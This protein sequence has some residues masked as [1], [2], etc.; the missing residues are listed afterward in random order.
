MHAVRKSD[1]GSA[2]DVGVPE[3]GETRWQIDISSTGNGVQWDARYIRA[4]NVAAGIRTG[5]R[6][7]GRVLLAR[8]RAQ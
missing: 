2:W 1:L 4:E 7:A 3:M 5:D 6:R 8:S